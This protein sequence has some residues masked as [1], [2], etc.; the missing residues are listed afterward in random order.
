ML[1]NAGADV[2][3]AENGKIAVEMAI[4]AREAGRPYDVILMDM[5]MPVMDGHEAARLLRAKAYA[6]PVIALTAHAMQGFP[7][8]CIEAGCDE[9]ATKPVDRHALIKTINTTPVA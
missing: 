4:E 6:G 8:K 1:R 9:Y 7:E 3:V 5:R 2:T